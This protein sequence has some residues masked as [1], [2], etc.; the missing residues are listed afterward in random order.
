MNAN[1]SEGADVTIGCKAETDSEGQNLTWYR[2]GM[3]LAN[4]DRYTL[5]A[6]GTRLVIKD[7]RPEDA[8]V[9][10]CNMTLHTTEK[11]GQTLLQD[12]MLNGQPY[13]TKDVSTTVDILLNETLTITCPVAGYPRPVVFWLRD[14]DTE[15]K[16]SDRVTLSSYGDVAG[17][18]IMI[19]NLTSSDLG[20]YTCAAE[21]SIGRMVKEFQVGPVGAA[22]SERVAGLMNVV[23]GVLVAVLGMACSD[24]W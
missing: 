7:S 2:N 18:R 1:V 24:L 10:T 14:G 15:V 9:Y 11:S 13:M 5:E 22:V 4:S 23:F 17:A 3:R 8:G 16:A 20:E 21:N 12:V 6:N 19:K